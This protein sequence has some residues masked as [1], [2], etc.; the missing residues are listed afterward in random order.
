MAS[1]AALRNRILAAII[2]TGQPIEAIFSRY[3]GIIQNDQLLVN[4]GGFTDASQLDAIVRRYGDSY[5][6]RIFHYSRR[7]FIEA[8]YRH[9]PVYETLP[10]K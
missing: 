3:A 6:V 1:Q 5:T 4:Y 7:E 9:T 10:Q 8:I 2:A